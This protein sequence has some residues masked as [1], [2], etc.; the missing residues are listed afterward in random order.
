MTDREDLIRKLREVQSLKP[1]DPQPE[2][3]QPHEWGVYLSRLCGEAADAI[4]GLETELDGA[5]RDYPE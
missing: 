3:A 5:F 4:E 1:G 2:W